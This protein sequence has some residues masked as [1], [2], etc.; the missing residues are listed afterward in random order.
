MKSHWRKSSYS[1]DQGN[2]LEAANNGSR[3]LVRDS[4]QVGQGPTLQF[5]SETWRKFAGR[6]K[7]DIRLAP[8]ST[9]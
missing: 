9:A 1:G 7:G 8:E 3:V 6:V 5:T 2:C 4:K